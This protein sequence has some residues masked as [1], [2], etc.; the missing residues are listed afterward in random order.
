MDGAPAVYSI[1]G[2]P[3]VEAVTFS[4]TKLMQL[5]LGVVVRFVMVVMVGMVVFFAVIMIAMMVFRQGSRRQGKH[6]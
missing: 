5:T 6:K 1:V 3:S 4:R 2:I